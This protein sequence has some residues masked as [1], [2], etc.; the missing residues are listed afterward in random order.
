MPTKRVT[1]T[2]WSAGE[3][4]RVAEGRPDTQLYSAGARTLRNALPLVTGGFKTRPGTLIELIGDASQRRL[5]GFMFNA[6]QRYLVICTTSS[7]E[8]RV[9]N[10]D[11]SLGS[12]CTV[13]NSGSW[14]TWLSG[15]TISELREMDSSQRS[16]TLILAHRDYQSLKLLRTGATTFTLSQFDVD[17]A[18]SGVKRWPT[19]KFSDAGVTFTPS[20]TSGTINV[21][22][23][24]A[25]FTSDMATDQ[26]RFLIDGKQIRA[27][28]FTS[29][30]VMQCV[31]IETLSGT[32]ATE[33][34]EEQAWS[35][36]RGWPGA[37][38]FHGRRLWFGGTNSLPGHLFGS[39]SGLFFDFDVET[40]EDDDAVVGPIASDAA[41]DITSL[42]SLSVLIVGTDQGVLYV[43]ET[44]DDPVR[45][46]NF[47]PRFISPNGVTRA[48]PPARYNRAVVWP[49]GEGRVMRELIYSTINA[50]FSAVPVVLANSE[51]LSPGYLG[52]CALY[53]LEREPLELFFILNSDGT[54]AVYHAIRSE[55][56][57]GMSLWSFAKPDGTA[58]QCQS[59]VAVGPSLYGVLCWDQDGTDI[60]SVVRFTLDTTLDLA[61]TITSG[62]ETGSFSGLSD[63]ANEPVDI[64]TQAEAGGETL[65]NAYY[66]GQ[67][68]IDGSGNL[69]LPDSQEAKDGYVGFAFLP[70]M[71]ALPPVLEDRDGT[72][73]NAPARIAETTVNVVDTSTLAINGRAVIFRQ[74]NLDLDAVP[75]RFTGVKRDWGVGW[76]RRPV[77]VI[78]A[79]EPLPMQVTLL[80][81]EVHW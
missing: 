8:V 7:I 46:A 49:Q 80:E 39:Q 25:Y 60:Y 78:S 18:S 40:G 11:D 17:T 6:L 32:S 61:T 3:I 45:P 23:S 65:A 33:D 4:D 57:R 55:E 28:S 35:D 68:T 81:R 22:A 1:Q 74:A 53:A 41:A 66:I 36:E 12:A 2:S 77:T 71:T 20:A 44:D 31:V 47:N 73:V 79:A 21:T 58:I 30:T 14:S 10:T 5:F 13:T 48:A 42:T 64:V 63:Y 75:T 24:S 29:S 52:S 37:V 56:I 76:Q 19:A 38:V 62:T 72:H 51:L 54:V 9:I 26:R 50:E 59:M 69:T 34:F 27:N 15:I 16:D 67:A 70:T 43:P